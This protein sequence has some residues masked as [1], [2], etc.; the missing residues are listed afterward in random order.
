MVIGVSCLTVKDNIVVRVNNSGAET[1]SGNI[2]CVI[3]MFKDISYGSGA[4]KF[5]QYQTYI[6]GIFLGKDNTL[7]EPSST[8]TFVDIRIDNVVTFSEVEFDRTNR[9]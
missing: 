8:V 9:I 2:K 3:L 1:N 5:S 4:C 6:F 7:L